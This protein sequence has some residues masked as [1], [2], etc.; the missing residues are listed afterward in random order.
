MT[1]P[2]RRHCI[3]PPY[4]LQHLLESQDPRVRASALTTLVSSAALRAR[5]E[6]APSVAAAPAPTNGRRTI[7]DC[8]HRTNLSSAKLVRTEQGDPS[9]DDAV[10]NAFDGLGA[11]RDF[12]QQILQRN[13][14]DDRGMRLD[15][16]VHRG[17]N[18]NNAF[19]DGQQMVFG[20][21]DGVLFT[22]FT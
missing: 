15:G 3:V 8:K 1:L 16:Y 10:N 14:I 13:S 21:G 19:W 9:T 4:M 20:D 5:R 17:R 2:H 6:F 7:F 18:F 12:Y 11:T 22:D